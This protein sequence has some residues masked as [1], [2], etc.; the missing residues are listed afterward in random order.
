M[1]NMFLDHIRHGIG[2]VKKKKMKNALYGLRIIRTLVVKGFCSWFWLLSVSGLT[3]MSNAAGRARNTH[4]AWK[5]VKCNVRARTTQ[6]ECI[7]SRSWCGKRQLQTLLPK[8]WLHRSLRQALYAHMQRKWTR[9][10]R[11]FQ[12][13]VLIFNLVN[14]PKHH[15]YK[16][17]HILPDVFTQKY[18]FQKIF[19]NQS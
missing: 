7:H 1:W 2:F 6:R 12:H 4:R 14:D 16:P 9:E 15:F 19:V 5:D 17:T 10:Y 13:F 3:W 8:L 18:R 11:I